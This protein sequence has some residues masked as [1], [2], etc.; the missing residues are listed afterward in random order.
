MRAVNDIKPFDNKEWADISRK[1]GLSALV[2][3]NIATALG[4]AKIITPEKW[5]KTLSVARGIAAGSRFYNQ[6]SI[7]HRKDDDLGYDEISRPHAA[8]VGEI[9]C[10]LERK[11]NPV[12]LP[13]SGLFGED[14]NEAV[15]II[16]H[17][18]MLLWWRLRL[19]SN[20][21]DWK[22]LMHIPVKFK[23]LIKGK[24]FQKEIAS[25]AIEGTLSPILG[26]AGVGLSGIFEPIKAFNKIR[27]VECRIID[28]L[29]S[30][31]LATQHAAYVF[32]FTLPEILERRDKTMF[33]LGIL[34]NFMN[35]A[36]PLL[37]VMN[38][39]QN[40]FTLAKKIWRE[41]SQGA[42]MAFFSARRFKLGHEWLEHS[43]ADY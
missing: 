39:D 3:G 7:H 43:K 38:I 20:K 17:Y 22:K 5:T 2:S 10:A 13:L 34:T 25:R 28:G 23:L 8:N 1:K 26:L 31:G 33:A 15:E 29:A 18:P 35:I 6:Y 24:G 14:I 16:N 37:D 30:A 36:L 41:V 40:C 4:V 11:I 21:I 19:L 32:R 27:K 12:A 9:G 42:S